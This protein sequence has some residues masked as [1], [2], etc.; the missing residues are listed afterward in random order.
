MNRH[1][2]I[3]YSLITIL[4]AAIMGCGSGEIGADINPI[5]SGEQLTQEEMA[6]A[7]TGYRA[8][9]LEAHDSLTKKVEASGDSKATKKLARF[10]RKYG[11]KIEEISDTDI[12]SMSVDD[13]YKLNSE[14]SDLISAMRK[15][16]DS[17]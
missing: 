17:I 9:M 15:I 8:N 13:L 3:R 14:I 7:V 4:L 10:N 5:P 6:E 16:S 11:K 2:I 1:K 12:P